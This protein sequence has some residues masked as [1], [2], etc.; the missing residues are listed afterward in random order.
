MLAINGSYL[1]YVYLAIWEIALAGLVQISLGEHA[2]RFQGIDFYVR[3]IRVIANSVSWISWALSFWVGSRFG[4]AAGLMFLVVGFLA[5]S[6]T[7]AYLHLRSGF[8][9]ALHAASLPLMPVGAYL[10]LGEI[11]FRTVS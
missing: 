8:N 4:I 9:L 2:M 3:I 6:L 7:I 11:G 5:N 10:T 1:P